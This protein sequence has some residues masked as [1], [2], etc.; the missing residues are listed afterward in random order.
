MT[1]YSGSLLPETR[2]WI[3]WL[4]N[5]KNPLSNLQ[6][7]TNA[8]RTYCMFWFYVKPLGANVSLLIWYF[9]TA[10]GAWSLP[11]FIEYPSSKNSLTKA[12][13][14][15]VISPQ[16]NPLT[17]RTVSGMGAVGLEQHCTLQHSTWFWM[18]IIF[19][20]IDLFSFVI[21]VLCFVV[22]R[23]FNITYTF[24]LYNHKSRNT[25]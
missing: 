3:K 8:V 25:T 17:G 2:M 4:M 23:I 6:L 22:Q 19:C 5:K 21:Y 24:S 11:C 15:P 18:L 1:S 12:S 9:G 7:F 16:T 20:L 13:F 10:D 14:P